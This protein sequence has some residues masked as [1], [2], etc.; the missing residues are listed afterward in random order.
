MTPL[1][2]QLPFFS[3]SAAS[4][5]FSAIWQGAVLA[6]C[7]MVC[8]RLLPSLSAAARSVIWLN[9]FVLLILLHFVPAFA[10]P[11]GLA[12]SVHLSSF[13][14]DWRWS[15]GIVLLWAG[16]S[17]W[18]AFQ[19][20][21]GALHLRRLARRAIPVETS[22]ELALILD[23]A[24]GGRSARLCG[25]EEVA[26]PSVL[27]FFHPRVLIPG[28][29]LEVL[30][31][32][33]LQQVVLHEMEHLRRADDWTNLL[34]KLGLVLFP[35]NPVLLWV[36]HRLCA[37][38]ELACDD[39]V[40]SSIAGRKAY[41]LCLTHLAE[42]SLLRRSFSLVLGAFERRSELFRRVQ[43][44]MQQ[45]G[46]TMSRHAAFATTGGLV[47]GA[48]GCALIL[49]SSPQLVSFG[50]AQG[51]AHPTV[52]L[53]RRALGRALGAT[54]Q[55]VKAVVPNN[56]PT[57]PDRPAAS[58]RKA[59]VK[60]NLRRPGQGPGNITA[61]LVLLPRLNQVRVSDPE[62]DPEL[63]QQ[64]ASI[65]LTEF[66]AVQSLPRVVLAVSNDRRVAPVV[67]PVRYAVV[68][69]PNGWLIIRI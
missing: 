18:R 29:L 40:V 32:Q 16:S 53:D 62:L 9:V 61:S 10:A 5:L 46:R 33:E 39:R 35:L 48:L 15:L 14:F 21:S 57:S 2:Q 13:H 58:T 8:L 54:P 63:E 47:S 38:R 36:E 25:S 27:G 65:V 31:P 66:R 37:E 45:P 44:I 7:V 6:A 49:A 23:D 55:L 12:S 60:R 11:S 68:P 50:P 41:A 4:A 1:L 69:T 28:S 59:V 51:L 17:A 43:R 42:Y 22:P 56:P 20:A 64:R 19:L 24:P 3:A 52:N 67:I 26:R 30:S 34:Q